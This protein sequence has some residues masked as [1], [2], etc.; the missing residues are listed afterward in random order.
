MIKMRCPRCGTEWHE[1]NLE[2]VLRKVEGKWKAWKPYMTKEQ[3]KILAEYNNV[4]KLK[5]TL[6]KRGYLKMFCIGCLLDLTR[7]LSYGSR[8]MVVRPSRTRS[9]DRV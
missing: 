2:T 1:Q 5:E 6:K 4:E 8:G 3:E 7:R 9:H